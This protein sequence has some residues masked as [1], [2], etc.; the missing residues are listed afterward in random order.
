M[1]TPGMVG[2]RTHEF[3]AAKRLVYVLN[4]HPHLEEYHVGV[5]SDLKARPADGVTPGKSARSL[6]CLDRLGHCRQP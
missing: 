1:L 5:A 6:M 2:I 3:A 4:E